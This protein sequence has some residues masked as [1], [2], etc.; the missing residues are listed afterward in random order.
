MDRKM[1]SQHWP[2]P[3]YVDVPM[4]ADVMT[5]TLPG[6][7]AAAN[8]DV[9]GTW[10]KREGKEGRRGE[11]ERGMK[12][13]GRKRNKWKKREEGRERPQEREREGGRE[14]GIYEYRNHKLKATMS[15]V[16]ISWIETLDTRHSRGYENSQRSVT[17]GGSCSDQFDGALKC[18]G[19]GEVY[20]A[21]F[22]NASGWD[23]GYFHWFPVCATVY[24]WDD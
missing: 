3:L 19:E 16:P 8:G 22:W 15:A 12:G 14:G 11:L 7:L 9:R 20:V 23:G 6:P 2:G 1:P 17:V 4:F 21:D 24:M 18:F 13:K 5:T 10:W